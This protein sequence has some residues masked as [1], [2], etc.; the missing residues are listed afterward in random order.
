MSMGMAFFS[1][2]GLIGSISAKSLVVIDII[3]ATSKT[4]SKTV[5]LFSNDGGYIIPLAPMRSVGDAL[6]PVVTF[7]DSTKKLSW[8]PP[9]NHTASAFTS[10][11]IIMLVSR[12]D[13]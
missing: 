8:A 5:P 7:N 1:T 13:A 6:L 2:E 9:S 12:P 3:F 4:G 10:N 11:F